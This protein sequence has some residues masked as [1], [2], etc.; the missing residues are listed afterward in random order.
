MARRAFSLIHPTLRS[1]LLRQKEWTQQQE[2]S[3]GWGE[4]S[5]ETLRQIYRLHSFAQSRASAAAAAAAAAA[6]TSQAPPAPQQPR[7]HSSVECVEAE[8]ERTEEARATDVAPCFA[9]LLAQA[10]VLCP[11]AWVSPSF[12]GFLFHLEWV[13]W[14]LCSLCDYGYAVNS[15]V[16]FSLICPLR[17]LLSDGITFLF[18]KFPS[19]KST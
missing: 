13:F 11:A 9:E 5:V 19:T 7:A 16:K 10:Y 12:P 4:V 1:W 14:W 17:V 8:E 15:S 2:T 18:T 3:G 6:S